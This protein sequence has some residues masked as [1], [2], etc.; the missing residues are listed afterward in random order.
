MHRRLA[1][2]VAIPIALRAPIATILAIDLYGT[3]PA[4]EP[5]ARLME[6]VKRPH[7]E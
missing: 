6:A 3:A 2:V 1:A 7:A 5:S 4:C